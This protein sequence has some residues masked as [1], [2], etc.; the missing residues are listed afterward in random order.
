MGN[1]DGNEDNSML[2]TVKLFI[3]FLLFVPKNFHFVFF[4]RTL[5]RVTLY[6]V[7]AIPTYYLSV[8]LLLVPVSGYNFCEVFG[9]GHVFSW[10]CC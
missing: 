1:L 3:I 10:V 2:S 8:C 7:V 4:H 6:L 5:A 9:E